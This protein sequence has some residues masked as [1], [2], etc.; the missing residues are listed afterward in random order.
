MDHG[1]DEAQV[2]VPRLPRR[3]R[4]TVCRERGD[5]GTN[6]TKGRPDQA[7]TKGAIMNLM[8]FPIQ[9]LAQ[10]PNGVSERDGGLEIWKGLRM[11]LHFC[12]GQ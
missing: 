10:G 7:R 8:G 9:R 1:S 5:S 12:L 4:L 6:P 11:V 2:S 3:S